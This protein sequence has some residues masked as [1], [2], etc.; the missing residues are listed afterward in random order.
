[1]NVPGFPIARESVQ[2]AGLAVL[3]HAALAASAY[4]DDGVQMSL[5]A[6]GVVQRCP[7]CQE[8]AMALHLGRDPRPDS[9]VMMETLRLVK[10]VELRTRHLAPKAAE[11]L[12]ARIRR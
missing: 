5:T 8:R 6:A 7:D 1:M 2:A 10:A 11:G 9:G 4:I 12:M 3:P